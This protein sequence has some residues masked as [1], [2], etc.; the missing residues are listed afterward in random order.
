MIG[1]TDKQNPEFKQ[2]VQ[3][4]KQIP[5]IRGLNH[6]S[7]ASDPMVYRLYEVLKVYG[8][9]LRALV[10]E[11]CGNGIVS[12]IDCKLDCDKYLDKSTDSERVVIKIDGK[13]LKYKN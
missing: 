6:E 1:I 12:A 4:M 8:P 3:V 2:L 11:M 7:Y 10:T 13:F 5:E 9:T